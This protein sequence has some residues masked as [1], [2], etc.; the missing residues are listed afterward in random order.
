MAGTKNLAEGAWEL[1]SS[2]CPIHRAWHPCAGMSQPKRKDTFVIPSFFLLLAL[3]VGYKPVEIWV[4]WP[5]GR[6]SRPGECPQ[7]PRPDPSD[8]EQPCPVSNSKKEKDWRPQS[9][10]DEASNQST[11]INT[12][13]WAELC[14]PDQCLLIGPLLSNWSPSL[15]TTGFQV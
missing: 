3:L 2:L 15:G 4:V 11:S 9:S 7:V 14:M 6:P 12:I 5:L 1:K 10:P 13:P 8:W